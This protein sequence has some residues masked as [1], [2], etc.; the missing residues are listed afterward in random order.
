MD[1]RVAIVPVGKIDPADVEAAAARISKV[2]NKT[3]E[4]RPSVP[5]PKAGD[6]PRAAS[7]SPGRSSQGCAVRSRARPEQ[8]T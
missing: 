6:D 2:L 8:R 4:L 7:T 1:L 5:V 3:V